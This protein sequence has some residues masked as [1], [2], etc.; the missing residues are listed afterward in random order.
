M[1]GR[2][3]LPALILCLTVLSAGVGWCDPAQELI[4]SGN[5]AFKA[6]DYREAITQY[7]NALAI[8]PDSKQSLFNRALAYYR[9]GNLKAAL[10]D[11]T[12]VTEIDPEHNKAQNYCGLI[13]LRQENYR[14]ALEHFEKAI[15]I[16]PKPIY[17]LNAALTS[18]KKGDM[19]RAGDFSKRVLTTNPNN[20]WAKIISRKVGKLTGTPG[21]VQATPGDDAELP[22]AAQLDGE[23]AP[24]ADAGD[25]RRQWA[26]L[27]N[28]DKKKNT[29]AAAR[30]RQAVD[31]N[32][33]SMLKESLTSGIDVDSRG[34]TGVT[35]LMYAS[36]KGN[37]DAVRL[38]I[39]SGANVNLRDTDGNTALMR[40]ADRFPRITAVLLTKGADPNVKNFRNKTP[41]GLAT[42]RCLIE[43]MQLLIERGA[44]PNQTH[45]GFARMSVKSGGSRR[46]RAGGRGRRMDGVEATPL[47]F[48]ASSGCGSGVRLLLAAGAGVNTIDSLGYTPLDHAIENG[49][50]AIRSI[51]KSARG[52]PNKYKTG[53]GSKE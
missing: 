42:A 33:L 19:E 26:A 27:S 14:K 44:D 7:T 22:D 48:A 8:D 6:G 5:K 2:N 4:L 52:R 20:K 16:S 24:K 11:F 49:N 34:P 17:L 38:L 31:S 37:L 53:A 12:R 21:D 40:V 29:E 23:E 25:Y 1:T 47:A 18:F 15:S 28:R 9:Q 46:G 36:K 43:T 39:K 3:L 41:L 32:N 51:L 13:F 35:A 10:S 50:G 45:T 30:L